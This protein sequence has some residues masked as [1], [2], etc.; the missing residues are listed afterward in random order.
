MF[1]VLADQFIIFT[2]ELIGQI[3]RKCSF[4]EMNNCDF[5]IIDLCSKYCAQFEEKGYVNMAESVFICTDSSPNLT[6]EYLHCYV[7][8]VVHL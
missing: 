4:I 5:P 2:L 8:D 1:Q 6:V 7:T 3:L